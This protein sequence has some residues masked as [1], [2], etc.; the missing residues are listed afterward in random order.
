LV[1]RPDW[2]IWQ[3]ADSGDLV[4]AFEGTEAK[5]LAGLDWSIDPRQELRVKLQA[6][7]ID[8]RARRA[9]RVAAAGRAV[10]AADTVEDFSVRNLAFQIR[11]RY[12][13]A[14]LSY[15]YVVY[16]RGGFEQGVGA[17]GADEALLDSFD[18]RQ[19][20]Q[21]MVKLSYRFELQAA[22]SGRHGVAQ[23]GRD[24][25]PGALPG[26][27]TVGGADAQLVA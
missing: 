25:A 1:R 16:A 18:L 9:W 24:D 27:G 13:L 17:G 15:L 11:Y 23:V 21:L 8:A 12:E 22:R 3:G 5:L 7:G 2:L 14:P 26:V 20:E 6:I 10:A 19:D 4:G